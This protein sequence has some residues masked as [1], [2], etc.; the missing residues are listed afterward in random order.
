MSVAQIYRYRPLSPGS[1]RLLSLTPPQTLEAFDLHDAPPYFALSYAWGVQTPRA[2]IEVGGHI[3]PISTSLAAAIKELQKTGEFR[4]VWVDKICINQDD[5]LERSK[6][7]QMM[8]LIY[9]SAL[10]TLIWL[11]HDSGE[12]SEAWQ[13]V[14][15][16]YDVFRRENPRAEFIADIPFRLYSAQH[17]TSSGLPSLDHKLW[18]DLRRLLKLPWF[19][20]VWIIQEV[21]LSRDDPTILHGQQRYQWNRLAWA[22]SWLRRNGYL[23]L[24]QIPN[25]M[26]NV[27]TISNIQRSSGCWRLDA[28]LVTTSTKCH[29]SDQRD[30]LYGLLGLAAEMQA[31]PNPA[32]LPDY[33][34]TVD[35]IYTNAALYFLSRSLSVLTRANGLSGAA[36]QSQRV[37]MSQ[38]EGLPTWVPNWC[39]YLV[40]ERVIA[41]SLSWLQYQGKAG[42]VGV[43]GFPK[44]YN[45]SAGREICISL[46]RDPAVVRLGGLKA[47]LVRYT[48]PFDD[49]KTQAPD[50]GRLPPLLRLWETI[51]PL[52]LSERKPSQTQMTTLVAS[53]VKA[54]TAEQHALAGR[55]AE[56][57]LKDGLAYLRQH[58]TSKDRCHSW[59]A[60]E[61]LGKIDVGG[62]GSTYAALASN[63]C[64]G[65]N[66]ILT[67]G[68]HIG[69]APLDTS[70]GDVVAVLFGGGV[71]YILRQQGTGFLFVGESYV[72]GL[73]AGEAI[74]SFER[75]GLKKEM[76][77]LR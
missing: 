31:M 3:L 49:E 63:F 68:G 16:I 65:R 2:Q 38:L 8:H 67:H 35:K 62:D 13:L 27:D 53:W 52:L 46:T 11:G 26:Q 34:L 47:D 60:L 32:L 29:A 66:F 5:T 30:K 22:A 43:L 48:I 74:E 24:P 12:C 42:E 71:P 54:T 41:K 76:F 19:T 70:A 1:I 18:G 20:R 7:V 73:M 40:S 37:N 9:S 28:L 10:R 23:R 21:V 36:T 6:Q 57:M 33:N 59:L 15:H 4:W 45:A 69:I 55:T 44:H 77:E 64:F 72:S 50:D 39:D 25:T 51:L 17:H 75:Q 14:D 56:E 58:Y 61:L